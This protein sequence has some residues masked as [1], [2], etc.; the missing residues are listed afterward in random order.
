LFL[1]LFL[2][3]SLLFPLPSPSSS[4][5]SSSYFSSDFFLYYVSLVWVEFLPA[6][7][8]DVKSSWSLS[9]SPEIHPR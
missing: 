3:L 6:I 8:V 4:L 5:F 7:Y 9:I 1:L 2:L